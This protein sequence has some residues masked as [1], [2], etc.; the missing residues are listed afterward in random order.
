MKAADSTPLAE[1]TTAH[2]WLRRGDQI[3]F[4]VLVIAALLLACVHWVRLSRWGTDPVEIEHLPG[5]VF[6][7]RIDI[8]SA[9]WVEWVQLE[10]IGETLARRIVADRELHGPFRS[11][12]DL[13]RVAGIGPKTA[14]RLRP[15]L[16]CEAVEGDGENPQPPL[17]QPAA[18][19]V[20]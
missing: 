8:N 10:G 3:F 13:Q 18:R 20:R 15:W 4:G 6:D 7:Y 19:T 17:I 14:E 2:F 9:T 5:S 11:V 16:W 1:D 12:G